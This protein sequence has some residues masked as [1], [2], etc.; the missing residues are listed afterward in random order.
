VVQPVDERMKH[1]PPD[2][3]NRTRRRRTLVE[4]TRTFVE[5]TICSRFLLVSYVRAQ[6]RCKLVEHHEVI[7]T[8]A[9]D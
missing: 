4:K 1:D 3:L 8:L 7:N 9:A 2:R 5:E 6:D